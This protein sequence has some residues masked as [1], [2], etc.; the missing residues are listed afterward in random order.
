MW[1]NNAICELSA[2]KSS[3][4]TVF[5]KALGRSGRQTSASLGICLSTLDLKC[6]S[7]TCLSLPGP[8]PPWC[9]PEVGQTQSSP[10]GTCLT[11][12]LL[13][14]ERLRA[15]STEWLP[16][17]HRPLASLSLLELSTGW[18][19]GHSPQRCQCPLME[20]DK[21]SRGVGADPVQKDMCAPY[22]GSCI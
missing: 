18:S 2:H 10:A 4:S 9:E 20:E 11:C 15:G 17:A 19:G 13:G 16:I 3:R 1:G 21:D 6:Y 22:Q 7:P 12:S 14:E 5:P 8:A